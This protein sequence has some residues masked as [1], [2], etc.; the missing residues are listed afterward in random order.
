LRSQ[1]RLPAGLIFEAY[2][3][4]W[5]SEVSAEQKAQRRAASSEVYA[6]FFE[7]KTAGTSEFVGRENARGRGCF[8]WLVK[9]H[10]PDIDM[11]CG[12]CRRRWALSPR[13]RRARVLLHCARRTH[14]PFACT[15]APFH[16]VR[17]GRKLNRTFVSGVRRLAENS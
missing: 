7:V 3:H 2:F 16:I 11:V 17:P 5:D 4:S 1:F 6:V 12:K 8:D 9:P 15:T 13:V 10:A 14:S